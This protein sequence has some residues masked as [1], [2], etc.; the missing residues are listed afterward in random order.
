MT[1]LRIAVLTVDESGSFRVPVPPFAEFRA[2]VLPVELERV[3]AWRERPC[4]ATGFG[5]LFLGLVPSWLFRAPLRRARHSSAIMVARS[6]YGR[7]R[8]GNTSVPLCV[9]SNEISGALYFVP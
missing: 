9:K 5:A 4:P 7:P 6:Y 3:L 8:W 2:V 1:T